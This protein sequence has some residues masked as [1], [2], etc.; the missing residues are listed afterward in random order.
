[1]DTRSTQDADALARVTAALDKPGTEVAELA[2]AVVS[3]GR[4]NP[5]EFFKSVQYDEFG[6]PWNPEFSTAMEGWMEANPVESGDDGYGDW[7]EMNAL[8]DALATHID[9]EMDAAEWTEHLS[10]D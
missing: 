7:Q 4:P 10:D 5:G 9:W 3:T 2:E 6:E 1:M 8:A